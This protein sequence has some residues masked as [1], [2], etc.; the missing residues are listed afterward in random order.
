[1]NEFIKL[2]KYFVDIQDCKLEEVN[3]I[4]QRNGS[5]EVKDSKGLDIFKDF[6]NEITDIAEEGI[7]NIE[8]IIISGLITNAPKKIKIY[9]EEYCINK[10]FI[11]TIK[12]VFGERVE[13]HRSYNDILKK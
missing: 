8:D 9:N 2:L 4:V 6:L 11:Q 1:Y 7:I 13:T 5:Y 3:I 12:S 10:E